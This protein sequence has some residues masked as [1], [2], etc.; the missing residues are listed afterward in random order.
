MYVRYASNISR[1]TTVLKLC[2]PIPTQLIMGALDLQ[3]RMPSLSLSFCSLLG[4]EELVDVD[5]LVKADVAEA[6][7]VLS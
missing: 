4:N 7:P 2:Q 3:T 6:H 5:P 1:I